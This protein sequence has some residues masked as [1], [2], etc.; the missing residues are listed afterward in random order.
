[1]ANEIEIGIFGATGRFGQAI[2]IAALESPGFLIR[3]AISRSRLGEDYGTF[4]GLSPLHLSIQQI[5]QD[6]LPSVFIDVSL[7]AGLEERLRYKRPMVIGTTALSSADLTLIEEASSSIPI[8]YSTNFS[9]GM[10]LL[11]RAAAEIAR[12]F[13]FDAKIDL[14]ETHHAEKKDAPSGSAVSLAAAIRDSNPE[15]SIDIHSI[16]SG[17]IIGEHTLQFNTAEERIQLSHQAHSRRAFARGALEAAQ[18]LHCQPPGL[19]GMDDLLAG[20]RASAPS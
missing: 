14:I 13:H 1:M 6:P 3:A 4:L 17:K 9:L 18:F 16:R 7:P 5:P 20:K 8:F 19:Y 15:A 10:A 11:K 12:S 2:A